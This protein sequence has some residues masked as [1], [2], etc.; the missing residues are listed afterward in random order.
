MHDRNSIEEMSIAFI[1]DEVN[2][3]VVGDY[4]T[5]DDFGIIMNYHWAKGP[6]LKTDRPYRLSGARLMRVLKGRIRYRINLLEYEVAQGQVIWIPDSA[7]VEFLSASEDYR[8]QAITF[9]DKHHRREDA[10]VFS[11]SEAEWQQLGDLSSLIRS[12]AGNEPFPKDVIEDLIS[13][14]LGILGNSAGF[15]ISPAPLPVRKEQLFR[16]FIALVSKHFREHRD[17]AF[18][19]RQLCLSSHYLSPLIR[20]ASGESPSTWIT[21]AIIS[22]A[23]VLLKQTDKTVLQISE[24]LGFPNAPFFCRYFKR[25]TGTTPSEYR[26][27]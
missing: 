7:L 22:E 27:R 15:S 18:Y 24:E 16:S 4:F 3:D 21:K 5:H 8:L 17:T 20:Q 26:E 11:L 6:L 19:A 25:E 9:N 10:I 2:Y 1:R 12:V 13:A 14:Y 23:K